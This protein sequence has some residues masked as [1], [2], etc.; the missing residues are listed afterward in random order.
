M[1]FNKELETSIRNRFFFIWPSRQD[2]Q[3]NNNKDQRPDYLQ[4]VEALIDDR[5]TVSTCDYINIFK[6]NIQ[7][8][9]AVLL[10]KVFNKLSRS[11]S[12]RYSYI[13]RIRKSI[14]FV[15]KYLQL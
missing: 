3:I 12:S 2:H 14:R 13:D 7:A 15:N 5:Y 4:E 11:P 1:V 10:I 9:Q 8:N 6:S